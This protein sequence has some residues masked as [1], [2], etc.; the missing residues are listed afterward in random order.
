MSTHQALPTRLRNL[1]A[2][3]KSEIIQDMPLDIELCEND[4]AK[5]QC[6]LGEWEN[7]ERRLQ[8]VASAKARR[9]G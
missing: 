8:H 3:L 5:P 6:S 1:L 9:S 2:R 7:C 4:C